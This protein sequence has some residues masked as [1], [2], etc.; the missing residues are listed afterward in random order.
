MLRRR[1]REES[2]SSSSSESE[3]SIGVRSQEDPS[4]AAR[5]KRFDMKEYNFDTSDE[6]EDKRQRR[7]F[8]RSRPR[9]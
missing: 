2:S 5:R 6:E 4:M 1:R 9:E 7:E 3:R 8:E